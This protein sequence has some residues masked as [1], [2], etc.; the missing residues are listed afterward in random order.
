M[1]VSELRDPTQLAVLM[2]ARER[3]TRDGAARRSMRARTGDDVG[4]ELRGLARAKLGDQGA[5]FV[6]PTDRLLSDTLRSRSRA[7]THARMSPAA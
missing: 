1:I 5:L 7:T 3:E 4:L 6:A 2:R